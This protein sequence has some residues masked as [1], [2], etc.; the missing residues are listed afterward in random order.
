[1][2]SLLPHDHRQRLPLVKE[3]GHRWSLGLTILLQRIMG[4]RPCV[5]GEAADFH[6]S[7]STGRFYLALW[8]RMLLDKVYIFLYFV[9]LLSLNISLTSI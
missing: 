3:G 7:Y 5:G 2:F 9:L 4:D 8:S 1:M 6:G